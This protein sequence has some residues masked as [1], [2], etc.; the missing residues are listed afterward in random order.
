MKFWVSVI[1]LSLFSHAALAE[2]SGAEKRDPSQHID[3][4]I[5]L[6]SFWSEPPDQFGGIGLTWTQGRDGFVVSAVGKG[7]PAERA[8]IRHGD[9]LLSVDGQPIKEMAEAEMLKK[10][11]GAPG[12]TVLIS[13]TR[14]Q[15]PKPIHFRM[16]RELITTAFFWAPD[17]DYAADVKKLRPLA[18]SGNSQAQN[19]LGVLY[20]AG[21]GVTRDEKHAAE[22]YRKAASLGDVHGQFNLGRAYQRGLGVKQDYAESYFWASLSGLS[23]GR[24]AGV[25][26][27]LDADEKKITT[28]Q[29]AAAD[30]RVKEW[31]GSHFPRRFIPPGPP[32]PFD[33][34][35]TQ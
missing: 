15:V 24:P 3:Q 1:L 9:I 16:T 18:E 6:N 21:L 17:H 31:L 12:S 33:A 28:Q 20:E 14:D 34:R 29:K 22:W 7:Y 23:F 32:A 35:K 10:I 30:E 5:D 13:I 8:G 27:L 2:T 26:E 19:G 11:R 4:A 25:S